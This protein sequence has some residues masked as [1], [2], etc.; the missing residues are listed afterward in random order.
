MTT[1]CAARNHDL[2]VALGAKVVIVEEAGEILESHIL[3]ALTP[4]IEHLILIG[5][6]LQLRPTVAVDSLARKNY[7]NI[8]LFERLVNNGNTLP[9]RW[10]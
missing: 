10:E 3:T 7:L 6:H 1:T 2:L 4:S 8:S 9:R 5:D